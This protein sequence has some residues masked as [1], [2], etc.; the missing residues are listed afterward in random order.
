MCHLGRLAEILAQE[1]GET[2]T[3]AEAAE[4]VQ[5]LIDQDLLV[6]DGSYYLALAIPLGEYSPTPRI[7]ERLQEVKQ[8]LGA[9]VTV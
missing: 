8:K 9:A 2:F 5:P 6:R 3:E 1:T 4:A 7:L